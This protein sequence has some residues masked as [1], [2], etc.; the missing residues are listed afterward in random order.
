MMISQRGFDK[1]DVQVHISIYSASVSDRYD[2]ASAGPDP[3]CST[4]PNPCCLI[5]VQLSMPDCAAHVRFGTEGVN[6]KMLCCM[7]STA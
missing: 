3:C 2:T 6:P 7:G 4:G 1:F 5:A